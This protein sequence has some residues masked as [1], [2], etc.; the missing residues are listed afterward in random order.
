MAA[1]WYSGFYQNRKSAAAL[2]EEQ[3]QA[4]EEL[5]SE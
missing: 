2:V 4:F 3:I 1:E 5:A